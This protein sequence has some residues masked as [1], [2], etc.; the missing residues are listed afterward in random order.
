MLRSPRPVAS[1]DCRA[2]ATLSGMGYVYVW[3]DGIHLKVRLEQEKL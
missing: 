1:R 2:S 3:V